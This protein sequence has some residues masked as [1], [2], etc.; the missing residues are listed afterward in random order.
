MSAVKSWISPPDVYPND[1]VRVAAAWESPRRPATATPTVS[2]VADVIPV[3]CVVPEPVPVA[4]GPT[5][6]EDFI[7]VNEM[8]MAWMQMLTGDGNVTVTVAPTEIRDVALADH[9]STCEN[10]FGPILS[11][12]ND[13]APTLIDVVATEPPLLP[14]RTTTCSPGWIGRVVEY[15]RTDWVPSTTPIPFS[16]A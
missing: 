12:A 13:K 9:V 15:V 16:P 4:V 7:P 8:Q 6:P 1:G 10:V 3:P 14:V 11:N 2:V 5:Y